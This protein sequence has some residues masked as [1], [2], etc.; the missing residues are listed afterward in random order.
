MNYAK[1]RNLDI[2][3]GLGVRVSL[4]VSGCTNNCPN[5]FNPELQDFKYGKEFTEDTLK[6]IIDLLKD[7]VIS[8]LTILGGEPLCQDIGGLL[9]LKR[10][11]D[12]VNFELHKNVWIYTGFK[13][14]DIKHDTGNYKEDFKYELLHAAD[15]VVDGPYIDK[16]SDCFLKFRGSSNQRIID[17]QHTLIKGEVVELKI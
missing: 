3:N 13:W 10:L 12:I 17:V 8:G 6:E 4:F 14:E 5:C 9:V 11:C 15:V 7:D 1:I 2:A 16:L